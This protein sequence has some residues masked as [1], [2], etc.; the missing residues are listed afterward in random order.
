MLESDDSS[1]SVVKGLF[2]TFISLVLLGPF[3][4]VGWFV[5]GLLGGM[6][7]K[8]SAR[9]FAAALIGG[10]VASLVL[11]ELSY[12][13]PFSVITDIT[14]YTGNIY[15]VSTLTHIF[16]VTRGNL[17]ADPLKTIIGAILEGTVIPAIGGFAGGSIFPRESE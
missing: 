17:S 3:Y 1:G 16:L 8:G 5:A 13:L 10:M 15:V 2:V 14:N 7:G 9:G 11:I 12:Y 6:T 4:I